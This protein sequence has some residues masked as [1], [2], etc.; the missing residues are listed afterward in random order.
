MGC[1]QAIGGI[2]WWVEGI[3][4]RLFGSWKKLDDTRVRKKSRPA[5]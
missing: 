1:L 4:C 3:R 5:L 2:V